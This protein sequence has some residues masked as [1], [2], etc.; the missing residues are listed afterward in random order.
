MEVVSE[1]SSGGAAGVSEYE[2][3][4]L[5]TIEENRRILESI[6]KEQVTAI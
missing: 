3:L 1:A 5:S 6:R 4:R 2:Q